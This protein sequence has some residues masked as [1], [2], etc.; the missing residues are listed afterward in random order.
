MKLVPIGPPSRLRKQN[1]AKEEEEGK[2]Q[3]QAEPLSVAGERKPMHGRDR[4]GSVSQLGGSGHRSLPEPN[5]VRVS[6]PKEAQ[7]AGRR[8]Q[9]TQYLRDSAHKPP[10]TPRVN[11]FQFK[12]NVGRYKDF[13]G[14]SERRNGPFLCRCRREVRWLGFETSFDHIQALVTLFNS[15]VT[16]RA[17]D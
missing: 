5:H 16:A 7:T 17:I 2:Q 10:P 1:Q 13:A 6:L 12:R 8:Y 4:V 3:L 15:L 11:F 9:K 14:H